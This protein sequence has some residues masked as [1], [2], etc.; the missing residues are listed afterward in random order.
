ML[1]TIIVPVYNIENYLKKCIDSL[2]VQDIDTNTYEVI[3]VNDGST[4]N[5]LTILESLKK[6]YG[7]SIKIITQKN[8][9]LS[10]ARNTAIDKASGDYIL[11]VDS[12]DYILKNTLKNLINIAKHNDLDILEFGAKGITPDNKI[13]YTSKNSTNNNVLTGEQYIANIEYMSSAC[14]KLYKRKFLN[15]Y[16][17][18]FM[19]GVYIE[20]IE[21]NTRT[22]FKADKV[23][24]IETIVAHF[25]QREGSITRANNLSK[26]M[27][28]INDIY[29]V[30]TSINSFNE[31]EIKQNSIAY[32]P[33]K[34]RTCSLITTMLIRVLKDI[35]DYK[36]KK[37]IFL[38]LKQ[39]NLYPIPYTTGS[40]KK[41]K[42]R[43]FANQNFLFS[44]L[45]KLYCIKNKL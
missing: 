22:V 17:L 30:L 16:N 2:F 31:N 9:G 44:L 25:L 5:S 23:Q 4:D 36:V 29:T 42:F 10:G 39:Q 1:L 43:L 8:Q 27:K 7:K 21:F 3:A 18:K 20:D 35:N 26:T 24:A 15:K 6:Q 28:M 37:D 11:F 41:D 33:I 38:K 40:K 19:K 12:D 34:Q 32:V 45:C 13:V 14:N